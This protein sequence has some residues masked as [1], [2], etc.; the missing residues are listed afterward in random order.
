MKLCTCSVCSLHTVV[1]ANQE[2]ISGQYISDRNF[3]KHR[4]ADLLRHHT[5]FHNPSEDSTSSSPISSTSLSGSDYS[6]FEPA[7]P[8]GTNQV[9]AEVA[10][11]AVRYREGNHRLEREKRSTEGSRV[12]FRHSTRRR[13]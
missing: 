11:G 9:M 12:H 8:L 6:E 2:P 3:A 13:I 1:D 5:T 7:Q 4:N 10:P